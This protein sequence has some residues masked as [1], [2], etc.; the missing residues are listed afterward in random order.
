MP[1][2]MNGTV[3]IHHQTPHKIEVRHDQFLGLEPDLL[4]LHEIVIDQYISLN[5]SGVPTLL[6]QIYC[7]EILHPRHIMDSP[8]C[9]DF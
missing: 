1:Y 4:I 6:V 9:G 5:I 3:E 8:M 7:L 2:L